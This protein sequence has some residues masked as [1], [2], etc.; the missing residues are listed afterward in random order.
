LAVKNY[1]AMIGIA[2]TLVA[3]PALAQQPAPA[4]MLSDAQTQWIQTALDGWHEVSVSL[5][6][7]HARLPWMLLF[8]TTCVWHFM[9]GDAAPSDL[10]PVTT[11]LSFSGSSIPV[12]AK[13]HGGT[14]RLP[15]GDDIP[16]R[17]IANASIYGEA[18]GTYFV[19]ALPEVWRLNPVT[20]LDPNLDRYMLGVLI[21]E[22]VHTQQLPG[23]VAQMQKVA[24][25]Y[26]LPDLVL[27][28]DVI[29]HRF[30]SNSG[31]RTAFEAERDVLYDAV[32]ASSAGER[33]RLTARGLS[34][35]RQR[36]AKYF[37]GPDKMYAAFEDSFLS[38]EG[39][40]QWA[41]YR[42]ARAHAPADESRA[43]SIAFVRDNHRAWSQEEGLALFL[44]LEDLVPGWQTKI[45]APEPGSPTALLENALR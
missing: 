11:S 9:P 32:H 29:Q 30:E 31:F 26:G 35:I 33:K 27:D 23:L 10:A 43:G 5:Y 22:M 15:R 1:L 6:M 41:A 18:S 34:M 7:E 45:F 2:M 4:C 24:D 8:D 12:R 36:R 3:T 39:A 19:M 21:H 25:R 16:A 44:L 17:S 40:A 42:Y 13:L 20:A 14:I 28:D 37:K 38:L